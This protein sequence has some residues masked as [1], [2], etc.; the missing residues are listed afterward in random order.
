MQ[1][2]K[3]NQRQQQYSQDLASHEVL[4][5]Q[6]AAR[7]NISVTAVEADTGFVPVLN[8]PLFVQFHANLGELCT[9]CQDTTSTAHTR[10]NCNQ[11]LHSRTHLVAFRD[12]HCECVDLVVPNK[13]K[14]MS[15]NI[16][17]TVLTKQHKHPEA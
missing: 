17:V 9:E 3:T 10:E 5:G 4:P 8:D 6:F 14:I 12:V 13:T 16:I 15:N 7:N 1:K 11:Q 2:K